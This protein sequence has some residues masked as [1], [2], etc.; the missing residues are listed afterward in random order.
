MDAKIFSFEH[1]NLWWV[2]RCNARFNPGWDLYQS[3]IGIDA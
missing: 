3:A 2:A 1:R